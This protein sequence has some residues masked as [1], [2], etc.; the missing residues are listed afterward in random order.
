MSERRLA[1]IGSLLALSAF[2]VVAV[3][4]R[5]WYSDTQDGVFLVWNLVLAWIPFAL[6][7][8]V[9]DGSRHGAH[10]LSLGAL[11][12]LWLLFFPNAPYLITDYK[13]LEDWYGAP[14]WFDPMRPAT[15]SLSKPVPS[16]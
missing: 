6:A 12:G 5:I 1:V 11:T 9:Y 10:P 4:V 13:W 7:L 14:V 3:A 2:A 15:T 16:Q 8:L